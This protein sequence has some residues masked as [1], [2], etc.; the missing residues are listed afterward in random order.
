MGQNGRQQHGQNERQKERQNLINKKNLRP[1]WRQNG[2]HNGR[3][4]WTT[5]GCKQVIK[6]WR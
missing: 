1:I 2:K 3:Q 5:K 6:E 4:I